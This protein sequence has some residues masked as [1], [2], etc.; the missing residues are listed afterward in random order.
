MKA[1][2]IQYYCPLT[3]DEALA[4]LS[5]ESIDSQ[6]LA[7]GQSLLPM[8]HLRMAY[9][10]R[11]IDLNKLNELNFINTTQSHIE[12][13]AVVTYSELAASSTIAQHVPLFSLA[14]PHIAHSAIRNRGTI[15]GSTALADPAAEM[16]A[17]LIVLDAVVNAVSQAGIRRIPATEFFLGVY[18]T[19]LQQGELVHSISVPIAKPAR[20]FGFYELT[21]RHGDYAM[22]GAAISADSTNP[23]SGLRI[24]FFGVGEKALRAQDAEHLLNGRTIA[25]TDAL[26]KAQGTLLNL[27]LYEDIH[28]SAKVK[29][30]LAKV[31]LKRALLNLVQEQS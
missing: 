13:G 1:P 30:H 25:D 4:Q 11:L 23:Y 21:R 9:P 2:D 18:E 3:L 26:E 28:A 27:D 17:L 7:G 16:P 10:E 24:V 19:A 31:T 15:G 6:P 12:I 8:M 14:I 29:A 22:A 20:K 5:D